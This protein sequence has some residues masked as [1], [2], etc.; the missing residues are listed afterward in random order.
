[1][2]SLGKLR[3]LISRKPAGLPV[4]GGETIRIDPI[5]LLAANAPA[6]FERQAA[7]VYSAL[8]DDPANYFPASIESEHFAIEVHDVTPEEAMGVRLRAAVTGDGLPQSHDER[9]HRSVLLVDKASGRVMATNSIFDMRHNAEFLSR[10]HGRVL[11]AGLG[12]GLPV[13]AIQRKA[14]VESITIVE[15]HRE[16]IDL[17]ASR[18]PLGGKVR[19]LEGDAFQ[20]VPDEKCDVAWL[21]LNIYG[22]KYY[23]AMT[24]LRRRLMPYLNEGN[25]D[26][27]IGIGNE[28][29]AY[30]AHQSV[31]KGGR[32]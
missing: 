22:G 7:D 11:I 10:A 31:A 32:P 6:F 15:L 18:I 30:A 2:S 19:A 28:G 29:G 23:S 5:R 27:W 25:P 9:P 20:Y 1:M 21:F 16:V 8:Y 26:R 3:N 12:L 4:Q 24:E 13:L 17:V 14:E